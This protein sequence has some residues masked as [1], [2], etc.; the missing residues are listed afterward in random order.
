MSDS[1]GPHEMQHA[2]LPVPHQLPEFAQINVH[3][4]WYD[5]YNNILLV[6]LS[7]SLSLSY[8]HTHAHAH[9]H[10]HTHTLRVY[11]CALSAGL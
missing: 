4:V 6:L 3:P 10:T 5:Q 2:R 1:L 11:V 8:T 7:V 9:T